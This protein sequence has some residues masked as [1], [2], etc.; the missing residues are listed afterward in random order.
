MT[1]ESLEARWR[2][3]FEPVATLI[4]DDPEHVIYFIEPLEDRIGVGMTCVG[5]VKH[6]PTGKGWGLT[7]RWDIGRIDGMRHR[8]FDA[9]QPIDAPGNREFVAEM[10]RRL[11]LHGGAAREQVANRLGIGGYHPRHHT[12]MQRELAR[13]AY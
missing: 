3:S 10:K 1:G 9:S 12:R 7:I 6:L 4:D 13:A 2:Q 5:I 11:L 8:L